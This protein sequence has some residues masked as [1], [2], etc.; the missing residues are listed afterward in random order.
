MTGDIKTG[1]MKIAGRIPRALIAA[2]LILALIRAVIA[3]TTGLVDD[4]AYY[5]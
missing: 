1:N 3:G 5:R 2:I 4:E